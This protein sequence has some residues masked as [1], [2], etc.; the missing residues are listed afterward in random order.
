MPA[1]PGKSAAIAQ[2]TFRD[3]CREQN[4]L[5]LCTPVEAAV[6]RQYEELVLRHT[7]ARGFRNRAAFWDP[8]NLTS[9]GWAATLPHATHP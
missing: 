7:A 6:D 2:A 4:F 8:V 1:R 5:P 9:S 3:D